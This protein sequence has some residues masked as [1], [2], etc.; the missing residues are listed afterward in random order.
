MCVC[1]W[2]SAS[3]IIVLTCHISYKSRHQAQFFGR[4]HLAGIDIKTQKKDQSE[5]YSDLMEKRRTD[6]QKKQAA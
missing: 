1:V 4:G 2:P 3:L 5:F 6:D